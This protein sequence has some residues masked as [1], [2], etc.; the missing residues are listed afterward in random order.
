M[1][2]AVN[3]GVMGSFTFSLCSTVGKN[4]LHNAPFAVL[5]HCLCHVMISSVAAVVVILSYVYYVLLVLV[6]GC[7]FG[8]CI[9]H[10]IALYPGM[11]LNPSK[12][13]SPV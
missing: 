11:G 8:E 2:I 7:F 1:T 4:D 10:L 3:S 13:N 12:V 9:S 5:S 6:L